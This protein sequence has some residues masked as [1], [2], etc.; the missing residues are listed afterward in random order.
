MEICSL[1]TGIGESRQLNKCQTPVVLPL[2]WWNH[3]SPHISE[4]LLPAGF[5]GEQ[6]KFIVDI[7]LLICLVKDEPVITDT[8][9]L[10]SLATFSYMDKIMFYAWRVP[11]L[12]IDEMCPLPVKENAD[13]LRQKGFQVS[14][15]VQSGD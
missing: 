1:H 3:C 6:F 8:T 13:N 15:I 11:H 10:I 7:P 2:H 9:P 12:G 14:F 4:T 5:Q